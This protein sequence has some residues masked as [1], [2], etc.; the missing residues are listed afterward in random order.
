MIPNNVLSEEYR[1]KTLLKDGETATF[2]LLNAGK[3]EGGREEPST[4]ETWSLAGKHTVLDPKD[5]VSPQK[6]I[7]NVVGQIQVKEG[8]YLKTNPNGTPMMID[9]ITRVIFEKGRVTLT[10]EKNNTFQYLMRRKDNLSNPFRLQM[11]GKSVKAVFK[12]LDDKRERDSLLNQA[13]LKFVAESLVRHAKLSDLKA[14]AIK[15]NEHADVRLHV[16][17]ANTNDFSALKLEILKRAAEYPKFVI[18]ASADQMA[19][20][21]VQV[22]EC[23][24]F[25]IL[26]FDAGAF[27]LFGGKEAKE[28]YRPAVDV[29]P[30]EALMKFLSGQDKE[31][32]K[33]GQESYK[34]MAKALKDILK[35]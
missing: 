10:A 20:L 30:V 21:K 13:D 22:F 26:Q 33:E 34:E 19:R 3:K 25:G 15:L 5:K 6:T 9:E 29:D 28:I 1:V 35:V 27:S 31:R 18:N 32:E 4:P 2:V 12:L 23:Q 11:G 7:G 17:N 16:K 24:E 8:G 14:I